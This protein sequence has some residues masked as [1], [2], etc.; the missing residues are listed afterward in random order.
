[1]GHISVDNNG[2]Q[3]RTWQRCSAQRP[4]TWT[5]NCWN[6]FSGV[7]LKPTLFLNVSL[8]IYHHHI[9]PKETW[10]EEWHSSRIEDCLLCCYTS[11]CKSLKISIVIALLVKRSSLVLSILSIHLFS[12]VLSIY[13]YLEVWSHGS[14]FSSKEHLAIAAVE[15]TLVTSMLVKPSAKSSISTW[16]LFPV[17]WRLM[18]LLWGL[19]KIKM[20]QWNILSKILHSHFLTLAMNWW[21]PSKYIRAAKMCWKN[22]MQ[23]VKIKF[24]WNIVAKYTEPQIWSKASNFKLLT[25]FGLE[26]ANAVPRDDWLSAPISSK[27]K[28]IFPNYLGYLEWDKK[29]T[30]CFPRVYTP[31]FFSKL[32]LGYLSPK[33]VKVWLQEPKTTNV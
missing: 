2:Y 33:F 27:N 1:M 14:V 23:S 6:V 8:L 17:T 32:N 7:T 4:E 20:K 15:T 25:L 24:L 18:R 26:K 28:L 13:L 16:I 5:R 11:H 19:I 10:P 21:I 29:L 9:L 3:S 31:L 12:W 22:S 30:Y